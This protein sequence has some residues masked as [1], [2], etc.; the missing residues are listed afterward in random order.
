MIAALHRRAQQ[1]PNADRGGRACA[2]CRAIGQFLVVGFGH[3]GANGK[4]LL[5]R[6]RRERRFSVDEMAGLC[7]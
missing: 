6:P 4:L 5:A 2:G 3:E 1:F 7:N